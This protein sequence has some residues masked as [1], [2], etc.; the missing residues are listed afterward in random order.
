MK[1]SLSFLLGVI[2]V[3]GGA[4]L[5]VYLGALPGTEPGSTSDVVT[6]PAPEKKAEAV[7]PQAPAAETPPSKPETVEAG[8]KQVVVPSFDLLR[9]EPSGSLVIAGTAAPD[10]KVDIIAGAT[11]LGSTKAESNGDFAAALDDA[12]KPGDHQ[13]V[14]RAT[15][16]DGTVAT[17][18]ETA[19]VSI[20]EKKDGQVLALVEKPGEPSRLITKPEAVEPQ[21][22]T[23][24]PS[25]AGGTAT[26]AA[27]V[28]P[29]VEASSTPVQP[30]PAEPKA[31]QAP[32]AEAQ[33][34]PA[35]AAKNGT[36]P[37]A[38]PAPGKVAEAQP[39]SAKLAEAKP[40]SSPA[41]GQTAP[42]AN[43]AAPQ[44]VQSGSTPEQGANEQ[45]AAAP[46]QAPAA[47]E[48]KPAATGQ[49][50][51]K[52]EGGSTPAPNAPAAVAPQVSVEAV[53]IEGSH[54]YVAGQAT[55]GMRVLVYANDA[56][57]G[58]SP[59]SEK[60]RFLVETEHDLAVGDYIIR[61]DLVGPTGMK[62]LAR[63]AVPFAREA[64]ERVAAVAP[65]IKA[66]A[67]GSAAAPAPKAAEASAQPQTTATKEAA[68]PEAAKESAAPAAPAATAETAAPAATPAPA[69]GAAAP[70][71]TAAPAA[72]GDNKVTLA[73]PLQEV[74]GSVIIRRGDTL[75]TIADRAYGRG[76]RYTTIYL[77]NKDQIRDPDMIW[78]GQVFA[79]PQKSIPDDEALKIHREMH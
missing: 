73:A 28:A 5:A 36:Q 26:K 34:T 61:A 54:I 40:A 59:V 43:G 32:Q 72:S 78:P 8:G 10:S 76:V 9:V 67:E 79:M 77:A 39:G 44:A 6:S 75:W 33:V 57:L 19:V 41:S 4:L 60:G 62:V 27:P 25:P 66:A 52:A 53:E 69:T 65:S 48:P 29:A 51:A 30:T 22:A 47:T 14:L 64:G 24:K 49:Q 20:P 46:T 37:A 1:K 70:S 17:S 2:V 56:L 35:P 11:Q 12:L 74:Q 13:L 58:A 15:S 21:A 45:Q 31:A 38:Q 23:Q 18:T 50:V 3:G 55:P 68:A 71:A 7:A 42:A 16:P 63:A